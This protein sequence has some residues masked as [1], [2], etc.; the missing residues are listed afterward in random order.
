MAR[1]PDLLNLLGRDAVAGDLLNV[2]VIPEER[3]WQ[4]NY[5]LEA[6]VAV[7]LMKVP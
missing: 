3:A 2:A 4:Q 6:N 1:G 7:L 5:P